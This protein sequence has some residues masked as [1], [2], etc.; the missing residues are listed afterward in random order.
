M[1]SYRRL[2]TTGARRRTAESAEEETASVEQDTIIVTLDRPATCTEMGA[3]RYVPVFSNPV[4]EGGKD[5]EGKIVD[6]ID[7]ADHEWA[8][9]TYDWAVDNSEV[10]AEHKCRNCSANESE[11]ANAENAEARC[12]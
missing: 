1:S 10:T 7:M 11:T 2:A 4:F 3:H 5:V 12:M 9:P 8:S 6:D